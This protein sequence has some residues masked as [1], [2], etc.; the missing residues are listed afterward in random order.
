MLLLRNL[1]ICIL[2]IL[3][4]KV[5]KSC[6]DLVFI[7]VINQRVVLP[8]SF[9]LAK[10]CSRI[11]LVLMSEVGFLTCRNIMRNLSGQNSLKSVSL[12]LVVF[13][14]LQLSRSFGTTI[15]FPLA[16]FGVHLK[17]Y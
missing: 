15:F 7:F 1:E 9:S 12:H 2:Y 3:V 16:S 4:S 5:L 11:G 6:Q 10:V 17:F 8:A 13:P 14:Q